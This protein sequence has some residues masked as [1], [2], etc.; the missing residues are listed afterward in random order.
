M[1]VH[2]KEVS[3]SKVVPLGAVGDFDLCLSLQNVLEEVNN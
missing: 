1:T 3:V 2:L